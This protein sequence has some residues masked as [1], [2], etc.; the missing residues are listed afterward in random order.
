MDITQLSRV[1]SSTINSSTIPIC[2]VAICYLLVDIRMGL[3]VA[4]RKVDLVSNSVASLPPPLNI[5]NGRA[6]L[7]SARGDMAGDEWID[8]ICRGSIVEAFI[9]GNFSVFFLRSRICI[10]HHLSLLG[11]P[12][13][14]V[15][16]PYSPQLYALFSFLR[17]HVVC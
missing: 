4:R 16:S 8:S 1:N 12:V 3:V 7:K 14:R 2:M 9:H 17:I 6:S 11:C 5:A 13:F 10:P 15:C